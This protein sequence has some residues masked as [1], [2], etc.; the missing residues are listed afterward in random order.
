L[1]AKKIIAAAV[2]VVVLGAAIIAFL[3]R[4][5]PQNAALSTRQN[6][7]EVLGSQIAKL[8]P[9][10]KVLVLANP[11]SKEASYLDEKSQFERAGI[12]GLQKGLGSKSPIKVVFPE[13]RPEFYTD[14][15]SVM[16]PDDSRTPL[17]FLV[18]AESVE[19]LAA[20]NPECN[21][22]VSLIGLPVGINQLSIWDK[23]D[24]RSFALL[25]PDLRVLGDPAHVVDAFQSGKLLAAV[26]EEAK[27]KP[28]LI[29]TREN[30]N[31]IL[32]RQPKAVGF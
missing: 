25:L 30:V 10:C 27:D 20:A 19:K 2:A 4:P 17:S 24:Q 23:K 3:K 12:R 6:A 11:F 16:M 32:R 31:D 26:G 29:V 15:A 7:M 28:A 1:T 18:R 8:R 9:G 5:T 14:R 21:V 22:I 13:I